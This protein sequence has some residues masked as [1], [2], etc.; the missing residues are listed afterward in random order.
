VGYRVPVREKGG[1][2]GYP[3]GK[4]P[5]RT[6]GRGQEHHQQASRRAQKETG[7]GEGV[8]L[9]YARVPAKGKERQDRTQRTADNEAGTR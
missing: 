3:V 5:P 6:G 2:C 1:R 9:P 4:K 8:T 7:R